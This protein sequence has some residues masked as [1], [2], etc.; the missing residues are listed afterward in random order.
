[1][2]PELDLKLATVGWVEIGRGFLQYTL[3]PF[4]DT[5]PAGFIWLRRTKIGDADNPAK[6]SAGKKQAG[7]MA[8]IA[9][10]W[11]QGPYQRQGV[12]SALLDEVL[13]DVDVAVTP[14]GSEEGGYELLKAYGFRYDRR[15]D[16]W[17]W[18]RRKQKK[19]K[20]RASQGTMPRY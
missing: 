6:W 20:A 17:V 5:H 9:W 15:A 4:E 13:R 11:V 7:I 3:F 10:I 2:T 19:P 8:D 14:T 16:C 18:R 1:M 12:A